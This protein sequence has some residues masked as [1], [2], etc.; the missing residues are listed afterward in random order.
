[1]K[2]REVAYKVLCD[3]MIKKEYANI[4]MRD[5]GIVL[6]E[7]DQGL[8][9]Q[10]VY[11][12]L[13]NYRYVR[14]QW[15]VYTTSKVDEKIAV[16]LDMSVYQLLMLDKIPAYA[17]VNEA[18]AIAKRINK[19]RQTALVNAVLRK[20]SNNGAIEINVEDEDQKLALETSCPDWLIRMWKAHYG[21]ES[22]KKLCY[23]NLKSAKVALRVN[24]LKTSAD[25]LLKDDNFVNG[26]SEDCLY[27]QGNIINT[28][29]FKD[30]YVFIQS[31]SSQQVAN[32]IEAKATDKILD[33][34][35]SPGTKT[36]Q[37]AIDSQLKA[38]IVAVDV[39]QQRVELIEEA[40][41]RYG[42]TN[43]K[44]ICA[45]ARKINEVYEEEGFDKVLLDAPCSGLGTL[46]HKPE[47]KINIT[48][49]DLDEIVALQE[50]L[51]ETASKMVKKG[52]VLV[53]STCTLNKKENEKQIEKFL[54]KHPEF[55][56]DKERTI[57]PYEQGSDGFYLS[58]MYKNVLS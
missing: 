28:K 15:E 1:M 56:L 55:S 51:L 14:Y 57:M 26:E 58:R 18:V 44:T 17:C 22:T 43:V 37:M 9:T 20:V 54:K 11:G 49:N 29:Y 21:E 27:Y 30:N 48:P 45:D 4:N 2:V 3:V 40:L 35:A 42:I 25:E 13:R 31:F 36:I 16:L 34:C 19:G 5:I 23:E 50:E 52:G 7:A 8:L 24:K 6:S 10:I 53:Y 46:K 12:T 32:L 41:E 33:M 39:Y 38:S 47:I